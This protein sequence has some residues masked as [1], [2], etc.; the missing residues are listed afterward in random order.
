MM[1]SIQPKLTKT[2]HDGFHDGCGFTRSS[3]LLSMLRLYPV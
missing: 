2:P 3:S 1:C